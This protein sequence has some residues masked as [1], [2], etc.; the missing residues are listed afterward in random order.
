M[1]I[2]HTLIESELFPVLA[3]LL[4]YTTPILA[5]S[6]YDY[7]P[8]FYIELN[9]QGTNANI[10]YKYTNY[11]DIIRIQHHNIE[12]LTQKGYIIKQ[13]SYKTGKY[14]YSENIIEIQKES[15]CAAQIVTDCK[16]GNVYTTIDYAHKQLFHNKVID[17]T[18]KM[19]WSKCNVRRELM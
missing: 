1:I 16:E 4:G 6:I 9:K 10:I 5:F 13:L 2:P 8:K 7:Y 15:L 11:P 12:Y 18:A 14:I 19:H 17:K 3:A